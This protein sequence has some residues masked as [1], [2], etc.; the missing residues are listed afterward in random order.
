MATPQ[1]EEEE[2]NQPLPTVKFKAFFSGN[3]SC[4][5]DDILYTIGKGTDGHGTKSIEECL[6]LVSKID[7]AEEF[8]FKENE[9]CQACN[10]DS[11]SGVGESHF[12]IQKV[13]PPSLQITTS[14]CTTLDVCNNKYMM[15]DRP[16]DGTSHKDRDCR[17]LTECLTGE[18]VSFEPSKV[19]GEVFFRQDRQCADL[20]QCVGK[21]IFNVGE[22]DP[23]KDLR[24]VYNMAPYN[25]I[26]MKQQLCKPLKQCCGDANNDDP[27]CDVRPMEYIKTPASVKPG[28]E[29]N[30][31]T[32]QVY[33]SERECAAITDCNE[34]G[35]LIQTEALNKDGNKDHTGMATSD[36][37]CRAPTQC[38]KGQYIFTQPEMKKGGELKYPD[39][40]TQCRPLEKC[41][42]ML[43]STTPKTGTIGTD[44]EDE[45]IGTQNNTCVAAKLCAAD[46]YIKR[47]PTYH[48]SCDDPDTC[49]IPHIIGLPGGS[50]D[51]QCAKL[52]PCQN[53]NPAM[54][55]T[56]ADNSMKLDGTDR[57]DFQCRPIPNC[58]EEE[59]VAAE[60]VPPYQEK[61]CRP[62]TSCFGKLVMNNPATNGESRE[63]R[64]CQDIVPCTAGQYI[65]KMP[66]YE[67]TADGNRGRA[68]SGF[69]CADQLTPDSCH[70]GGGGKPAE[71]LSLRTPDPVTGVYNAPH[72]CIPITECTDDQYES[73]APTSTSDRV[74][75]DFK[76]PS[77]YNCDITRNYLDMPNRNSQGYYERDRHCVGAII[78]NPDNNM[79]V[80]KKLSEGAGYDSATNTPSNENRECKMF[81]SFRGNTDS[82]LDCESQQYL[83]MPSLSTDKDAF[84]QWTRDRQCVTH[85]ECDRQSQFVPPENKA[86]EERDRTCSDLVKGPCSADQ[87]FDIPERDPDTGYFVRDYNCNNQKGGGEFCNNDDECLYGICF[88]GYHA[89][90]YQTPGGGKQGRCNCQNDHFCLSLGSQCP[91]R[92]IEQ[93]CNLWV[94]PYGECGNTQAHKN[95]VAGFEKPTECTSCINI[96][97]SECTD[98]TKGA[99]CTDFYNPNVGMLE[100]C[101][102]TDVYKT[103]TGTVSGPYDCT[104]CKLYGD[105][106]SSFID[107]VTIATSSTIDY[108]DTDFSKLTEGECRTVAA[109]FRRKTL[110]ENERNLS[111]WNGIEG[112]KSQNLTKFVGMTFGCDARNWPTDVNGCRTT[113][114][115]GMGSVTDDSIPGGCLFSDYYLRFTFNKAASNSNDTQGHMRRVGKPV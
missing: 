75:T 106:S 107:G 2:V 79:Y 44:Q 58:K 114:S 54:L 74:C 115:N 63:D 5:E 92:C 32:K 40:D 16:K 90:D 65:A 85:R 45:P 95:E 91:T 39:D 7:D 26:P 35:M 83:D 34:Q 31:I 112:S 17:G 21:V 57:N 111:G 89:D 51:R 53:R 38:T 56:D 47:D 105:L 42:N 81:R 10:V 60:A 43:F 14:C 19:N 101:G 22:T 69:D 24:E 76:A 68:I 48:A 59:W 46:E 77:E 72:Q 102:T 9:L 94:D 4:K 12:I 49:D 37:I 87:V 41:R 113:Y 100:K 99:G 1:E 23:Y 108:N 97:P 64:V 78:C 27:T 18:Y 67:T 104:G 36:R 84:N 86:T 3:A 29:N 93:K 109:T 15:I 20:D 61:D 62:M 103:T 82:T 55:N 71:W 80:S 50:G 73:A 6:E 28:T 52:T 66:E 33:I 98:P 88:K 8:V 110:A 11:G 70:Q 30:D 25:G 96:C 13:I